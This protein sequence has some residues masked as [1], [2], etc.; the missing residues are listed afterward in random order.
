MELQNPTLWKPVAFQYWEMWFSEVL[1]LTFLRGHRIAKGLPRHSW[2]FWAEFEPVWV[3]THWG[4]AGEFVR[5]DS[6]GGLP[7][8]QMG[9][10]KSFGFVV[11]VPRYWVWRPIARWVDYWETG[12]VADIPVPV[13]DRCSERLVDIVGLKIGESDSVY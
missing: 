2:D 10:E 6:W 1:L 9:W 11:A 5:L 7:F 8:D 3:G 4:L 12:A 13:V